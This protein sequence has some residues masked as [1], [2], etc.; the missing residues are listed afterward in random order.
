[1]FFCTIKWTFA[2]LL[3]LNMLV[4][5]LHW[6]VVSLYFF[7]LYVKTCTDVV[8]C[9]FWNFLALSLGLHIVSVIADKPA[10][11]L[12]RWRMLAESWLN[13]TMNGRRDQRCMGDSLAQPE[14]CLW[15]DPWALHCSSSRHGSSF[16]T[17]RERSVYTCQL[18]SA[19]MQSRLLRLLRRVWF[20][21][22]WWREWLREQR[23]L[24]V[25]LDR[26]SVLR[27]L[28]LC[29][30]W[31]LHKTHLDRYHGLPREARSSPGLRFLCLPMHRQGCCLASSLCDSSLA[32]GCDGCHEASTWSTSYTPLLPWGR[33]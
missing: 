14:A 10:F 24:Q 26:A 2:L 32:C 21:I 5:W 11:S 8:N 30:R 4:L 28:E 3:V 17:S 20:R 7:E 23:C 25:R 9:S 6:R 27:F 15:W 31:Y 22:S 16:C 19:Q 29:S 18:W 33:C 12:N 13:Q 1:M